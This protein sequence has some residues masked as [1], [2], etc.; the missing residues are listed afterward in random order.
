MGR[1]RALE[2]EI[3]K[4]IFSKEELNYLLT[5]AKDKL[6]NAPTFDNTP[7][8]CVTFNND[9][10]VKKIQLH[11]FEK[12][13]VQSDIYEMQYQCWKNGEE[14]LLHVHDETERSICD[15]NTLIYLNDDFDGGEFY[16]PNFIHKP[17]QGD[18]TFFNGETTWHGV[19]PIKN[20]DRYTIIIWWFNTHDNS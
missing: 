4:D 2:V 12:L 9:K 20:N 7:N 1:R 13:N 15:Y 14:S 16:T 8:T 17:V 10:L 11:I 3:F 19:K 5:E 6:K 18:V